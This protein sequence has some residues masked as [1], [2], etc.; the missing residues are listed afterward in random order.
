MMTGI[1]RHYAEKNMIYIDNM[2]AQQ[3]TS[4]VISGTNEWSHSS[5]GIKNKNKITINNG[6]GDTTS[7]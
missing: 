6:D 7:V 2:I 4:D 3:G 5:M 1:R